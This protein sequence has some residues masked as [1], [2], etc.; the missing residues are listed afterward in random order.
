MPE[1]KKGREFT[2]ASQM[3]LRLRMSVFKK[4]PN[5]QKEATH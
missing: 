2:L 1:G 5:S 3:T 4:D